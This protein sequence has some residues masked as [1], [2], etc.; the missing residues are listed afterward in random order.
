MG[1]FAGILNCKRWVWIVPPRK[2]FHNG[3][4]AEFLAVLPEL[5]LALLEGQSVSEFCRARQDRLRFS[6]SQIERYVRKFG[7]RAEVEAAQAARAGLPGTQPRAARVSPQLD[8][9][10]QFALQ[11]GAPAPPP[12]QPPAQ[13]SAPP[14][15]FHFD[16][17]DAYKIKF[18]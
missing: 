16:P 14:A 3:A 7:I 18:D 6:Y 8:A 9:N 4:K 13:P 1:G 10:S 2:G 11:S 12:R 5:R 17:M 15:D